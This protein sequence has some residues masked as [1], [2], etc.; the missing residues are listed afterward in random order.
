MEK[1]LSHGILVARAIRNAIRANR[2]A[3]ETPILIAYQAD[4]PES[5]H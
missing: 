4:S 5:R 2:F 1:F 3:V